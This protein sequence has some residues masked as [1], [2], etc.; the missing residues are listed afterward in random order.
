MVILGYGLLGRG[1][2]LT[3]WRAEEKT[4]RKKKKEEVPRGI[5]VDENL[6]F[7]FHSE[8]LLKRG[9]KVLFKDHVFLTPYRRSADAPPTRC[10]SREEMAKE[11]GRLVR[12]VLTEASEIISAIIAK[13]LGVAL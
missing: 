10:G 6:C 11:E 5:R 9:R 1:E 8:I 7:H 2:R 12:E 13:R 4:G 3:R